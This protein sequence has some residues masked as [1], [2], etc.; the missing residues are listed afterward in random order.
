[1]H[2]NPGRGMKGWTIAGVVICTIASIII[3]VCLFLVGIIGGTDELMWEGFGVAVGGC[4][5]AWIC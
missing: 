2:E 1:M 5:L 4:L 3:G